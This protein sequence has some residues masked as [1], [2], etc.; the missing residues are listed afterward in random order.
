MAI[1]NQ[2]FNLKISAMNIS[3]GTDRYIEA[4]FLGE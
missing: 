2:P 1:L 4:T 3:R